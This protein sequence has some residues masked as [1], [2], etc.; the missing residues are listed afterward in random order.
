MSGQYITN[1]VLAPNRAR[2]PPD[3]SAGGDRKRRRKVLSCY[4]CRRRKLQRDRV[5]PAC[6]R[7][8]KAGQESSCVYSE[9][10]T[11]TLFRSSKPPGQEQTGTSTTDHASSSSY[12]ETTLSDLPTKL[13]Y[14]ERRIQQLEAA[15]AR[16]TS[17]RPDGVAARQFEV[18][19]LP[20]T[21]ES[22]H[23]TG[24]GS[25]INDRET[26]LLRGRS[27]AT[28]FS[29]TTHPLALIAHVPE[30]NLFTKEALEMYPFFQR[31]K[32]DMN[33]LEA[34]M[35]CADK[36]HVEIPD[37]QLHTLL[38]PQTEANRAV[39]LYLE[40]Y[41]RIYHIFHTPS[42]WDAYHSMWQGN[43]CDAP[44]HTV[45][46]VLLMVA[47]VSCVG[48]AHPWMYVANSSKAREGAITIT[49]ACESWINRQS[50]KRVSAADFQIRFLLC[51]T[52]QTTARK[53]KRTWT[54]IGTLLR[55]CMSAG[56]H[57]NPE[58][59]RK[60]TTPLDKELRRRIWA[61]VVDFELQAS[62]D[63]GMI[64][65]PWLLQSDTPAPTNLHDEEIATAQSTS[66]R[67][68]KEFTSAWYLSTSNSTIMLRSTLNII[69]NNIRHVL[70]FE[71][72]KLY[73]DEIE[74]YM[75]SMLDT[76]VQES[77]EAHSL[78]RLKLLQYQLALHSRFL[79]TTTTS[80]ERM[81]STMII[82][83]TA[84][85]IINIHQRLTTDDK[86]ALQFLGYDLLRAALSMANVVS[87]QTLEPG[88]LLTPIVFQ[89]TPLMHEAIDMLTDKA[90][91]LGC[92]QRQMWVA[93][94]ALGFVKSKQKPSERNQYMKEAVDVITKAYDEIMAYQDGVSPGTS[95]GRKAQESRPSRGIVDYLPAV[96]G[97][98]IEPDPDTDLMN[99]ALFNF[100]DFAAWTFEDWMFDPNDPSLAIS[101]P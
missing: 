90:A 59:I 60:Q 91:R 72:V 95:L 5:M 93:L 44:R 88:I 26:M 37:E 33:A 75:N 31:A 2:S 6:G 62:F 22:I 96:P 15:L 3:D 27:F 13:R 51:L 84:S 89:H 71:Q 80:S 28:Q 11:D 97:Q 40:S 66:P 67:S 45:A 30:L 36:H 56:L 41:D 52:K 35:K 92:E 79:R 69:L 17:H 29:G 74:T 25:N 78:F 23:D 47:C 21:P 100:D 32:Q 18:L 16:T 82:L 87:V 99:S 77:E 10:A 9:D 58:L 54:E 24:L 63:R 43:L 46:T 86:R 8:V 4:D 65:A 7:C 1:A 39:D 81:F 76:S 64:S 19:K 85:K 42:F 50:Q 101:G 53:Y 12:P 98:P 68:A 57:R 83:E 48:P 49:Q 70:T 61:A 34:R 20:L 38:P 73:T 14:Q 94:A 55:F